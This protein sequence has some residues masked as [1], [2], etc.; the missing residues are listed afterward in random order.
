MLITP[1]EQAEMD[2]AEAGSKNNPKNELT[3]SGTKINLHEIK[4]K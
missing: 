2:T 1:H 4:K 3:N